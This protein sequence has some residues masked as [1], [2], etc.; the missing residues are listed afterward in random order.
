MLTHSQKLDFTAS[1]LRL[2]VSFVGGVDR[3][4]EWGEASCQTSQS[5]LQRISRM[6]KSVLAELQ[7]AGCSF[8]G[9]F[10]NRQPGGSDRSWPDS[11]RDRSPAGDN[12]AM[13]SFSWPDWAIFINVEC[14]EAKIEAQPLDA[15]P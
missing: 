1:F 7:V 14:A 3:Q 8:D 13:C 10:P 5:P 4:P 12:L 6:R 9:Y 15:R 11:R 2:A